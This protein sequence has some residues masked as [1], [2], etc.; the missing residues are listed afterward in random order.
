MPDRL[1]LDNVAVP[2]ALV[3]ALP[4]GLPLRLKPTD[5]PLTPEPLDVNVAD[6]F[7]VPPYVPD[8]VL[9][10]RD[11]AAPPLATSA[12]AKFC[13]VVTFAISV[14]E[15]VALVWPVADAVTLYV[16]GASEPIVY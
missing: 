12:S 8:A 5:L 3:D 7:V 13:V 10:A 9:T 16:T 4:T 15:T 6:R 11:V 1:M 14:T 2:D